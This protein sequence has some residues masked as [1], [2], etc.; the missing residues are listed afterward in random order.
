MCQRPNFQDSPTTPRESL[1]VGGQ[2]FGGECRE[3]LSVI[4]HSTDN[5]VVKEKM[6]ATFEYRQKLVHDPNASSSLL[7]VFPRFLD[8]PGLIDQDFSMMLGDD[9]SERFLTK[10]PSYFKEKS[11]RRKQKSSINSLC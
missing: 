1:L 2:L 5:S 4:G 7:D 11:H 9:V 10:W 8:T 3:A 6:R